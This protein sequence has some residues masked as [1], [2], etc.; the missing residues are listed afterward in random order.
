M[1]YYGEDIDS[2][3]RADVGRDVQRCQ[4]RAS[5]DG[6]GLQLHRRS[7]RQTKGHQIHVLIESIAW[8]YIER[9]SVSLFSIIKINFI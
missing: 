6:V 4:A 5:A 2:S 3:W 9:N 7:E 1:P 8:G